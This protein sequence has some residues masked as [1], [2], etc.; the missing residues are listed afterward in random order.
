MTALALAAALVMSPTGSDEPCGLEDCLSRLRARV[1]VQ[2]AAVEAPE[3][4]GQWTEGPGL[5]GGEL[6]LFEDGT[7]IS[8]EW[9]CLLPETIQ[10]KGQWRLV[11]SVLLFEP[12]PDVTWKLQRGGNRRYLALNLGGSVRLFGLDWSLE[13][14]EDLV[15]DK[16]LGPPEE[17]LEVLLLSRAERW[18]GDQGNLKRADLLKSAWRPDVYQEDDVAGER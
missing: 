16:T 12:G 17:L 3:L 10:D 9:G 1:E 2:I 6:Y 14:L 18:Q 7:Y 4:V 5:T 13:A 8:T 11:E 15:A